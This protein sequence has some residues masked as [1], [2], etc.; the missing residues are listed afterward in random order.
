MGE[1]A[2]MTVDSTTSNQPDAGEAQQMHDDAVLVRDA[3]AAMHD[4]NRELF[5]RYFAPDVVLVQSPSH[6][7]PGEFVG[8]AAASDCLARTFQ[9][10]GMKGSA[11]RQIAA[12]GLGSA[13]VVYE[14]IWDDGTTMPL[15]ELVRIKEGRITEVRPFAWD[16]TLLHKLANDN[17]S[18][19]PTGDHPTPKES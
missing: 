4:G 15:L 13:F 10:V 18:Q 11:V 8:L 3:Y 17:A 16:P 1:A 19:Q 6:L 12:D 14:L 2:R 9:A 7:F 5:G